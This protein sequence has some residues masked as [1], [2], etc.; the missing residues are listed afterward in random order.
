MSDFMVA[1]FVLGMAI[2]FALI[3]SA[4]IAT[5]YGRGWGLMAIPVV[6]GLLIA[7]YIHYGGN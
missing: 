7:A 3:A 1:V 4:A 6:F 2:V 5:R